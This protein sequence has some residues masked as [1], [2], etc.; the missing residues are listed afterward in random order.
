VEQ[1]QFRV[2][3]SVGTKLLA[4]LLLLLTVFIAFLNASTI[5]LLTEDKRAYTYQ[6]QATAATLA[7]RE[8]LTRFRHGIDTLRLTLTSIDPTKAVHQNHLTQLE[9]IVENQSD[10]FLVSLQLLNLAS[11]QSEHVLHAARE[12][13]LESLKIK[14]D[15]FS[16][17]EDSLKIIIPELQKNSYAFVNVSQVGKPP[18]VAVLY[19]DIKQAA[20]PKGMPIAVGLT[21]LSDFGKEIQ[22]LSISLVG[23]KGLLLFDTRASVLYSKRSLSEDPL[24]QAASRSTI[25]TGTLEFEA[26]R[27]NLIGTYVRPGLGLTVLARTE[28]YKA[29]ASTYAM[30]EKFILLGAMAIGAA[31]LFAILFSKTLVRP[32]QDLAHAT[33]EISQGNFDIN[34]KPKSP[35]EIGALSFSFNEMSKKITELIEEQKAKAHLENEL[36][37]AS[38]VQQTLI[39]PA[40]FESANVSIKSHYQSASTCGGDW[41]GFFGIENKL[42]V[43]IADATGHGFPSALITASARSCFSVMHKLAQ[44]DE[45]FSFS[46]SAMM[47]F[48]N[49]VIYDAALGKIMM[50]FFIGVF[51]FNE[52]SFTYSSAGHNPP[53]LFKKNGE[54]GYDLK[55]MRV[56]GLRLGETRDNEDF[57]ERTTSIGQGDI[58]FL[59]TDGLIEGKNASGEQYGKKKTKQLLEEMLSR[60]KDA[61]ALVDGLMRSFMAHNGAKELDDDVTLAIATVLTPGAELRQNETP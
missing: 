32:L 17:S 8:F 1:Q 5:L 12:A 10:L 9:S 50:T 24:L 42:C 51:D 53:W 7:G 41:W 11:A 39:P 43:M 14:R 30:S 6:A 52:M 45:T 59:Y 4:S 26:N 3:V 21:S 22:G 55:S 15:D 20:H 61:Q 16:L 35:D 58:L 56:D 46:P 34:L 33:Q 2:K 31:I 60:G 49:R 37:I 29:M 44:G 48:A 18:V 47:S 57:E 23:S 19:A 13:D 36:A 38:T 25:A 27:E 54:G 28:W 40:S